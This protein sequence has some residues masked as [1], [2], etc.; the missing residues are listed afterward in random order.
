VPQLE[1]SPVVLI[2]LNVLEAAKT[3]ETLK[4]CW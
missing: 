1:T 3:V 4:E 2:P